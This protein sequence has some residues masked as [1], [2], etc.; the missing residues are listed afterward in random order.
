VNGEPVGINRVRWVS[1]LR[2]KVIRGFR[3]A[4]RVDVAM[5]LVLSFIVLEV[6]EVEIFTIY[7]NEDERNRKAF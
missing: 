5:V 3:M 1:I 6:K 4:L 7:K 2:P